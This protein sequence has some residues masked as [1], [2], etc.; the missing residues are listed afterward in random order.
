MAASVHHGLG[1]QEQVFDLQQVTISQD[2][3]I[4][5]SGSS[6]PGATGMAEVF[7]SDLDPPIDFSLPFCSAGLYT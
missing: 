6:A 4:K 5:S 3:A 1:S 2:R 7:S